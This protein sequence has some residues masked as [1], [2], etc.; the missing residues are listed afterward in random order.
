MTRHFL[1]SIDGAVCVHLTLAQYVV[2]CERAMAEGKPA[3]RICA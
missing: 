2:A 1:V 3:P